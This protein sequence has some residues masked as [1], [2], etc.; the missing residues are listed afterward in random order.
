MVPR[1]AAGPLFKVQEVLQH[2]IAGVLQNR[3]DPRKATAVAALSGALV[4]CYQVSVV[5]SRQD[6]L[7]ERLKRLE[8]S[9]HGQR[10][11][12]ARSSTGAACRGAAAHTLRGQRIAQ[13]D[14]S[15][16][17]S[18]TKSARPCRACAPAGGYTAVRRRS[19]VASS[20]M[21]L[22]P[23]L[24]GMHRTQD[25]KARPLVHHDAV[26]PPAIVQPHAPAARRISRIGLRAP[27]HVSRLW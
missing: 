25:T 16:G 19:S 12:E 5:Q 4:R 27:R 1:V 6:E 8:D 26:A 11:F 14:R 21:L 7:E 17:P 22:L 10:A 13:G 23:L 18:T 20:R 24:L 2:T 15:R 9:T 3:I